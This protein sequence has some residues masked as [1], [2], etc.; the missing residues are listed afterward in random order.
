[1]WDY[2]ESPEELEA[3]GLEYL[4]KEL[5]RFKRLTARL[6]KKYKVP[7]RA[8]AVAEAMKKERSIKA[9]EVVPFLNGL[10]K[11]AVKVT[12][13]NVVGINRKYDARVIETPVYLSGIVPSGAA[14]SFDFFTNTPKTLFM[15]TTGSKA[16][17]TFDPGRTAESTGTRGVRALSPCI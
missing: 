3:K 1:M 5:P 13:K 11:H 15:A 14:Y 4:N 9:A 10:R 17:P 12:N 16:R 6:A 8:E 2:P 7:A